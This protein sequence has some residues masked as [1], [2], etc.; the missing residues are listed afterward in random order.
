MRLSNQLILL[1]ILIVVTGCDEN[2]PGPVIEPTRMYFTS[3]NNVLSVGSTVEV[4]FRIDN[5]IVPIFALSCQINYNS[6]VLSFNDS[7]GT[8]LGDMF[9]GDALLFVRDEDSTIHLSLTQIQGE[10]EIGGSG[11]LCSFR[12]SGVSAGQGQ[13]EIVRD[14]LHFYDDEGNEIDYGSVEIG[15]IT[16]VVQ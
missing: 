13:I 15:D 8:G 2:S 4:E 10:Q 1:L 5:L 16:L 9:G 14:E 3:D 7:T 11:M 12:F 6:D